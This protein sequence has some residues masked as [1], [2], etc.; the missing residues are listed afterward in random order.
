MIPTPQ[1]IEFIRLHRDDDVIQLAI[2]QRGDQDIDVPFALSQIR[3]Y[4]VARNKIPSW[5]AIEDIIYPSSLPLEQCS[6]EAT[7]EYKTSLLRGACSSLLDLTGGLGVDFSFMSKAVSDGKGKGCVYVERQAELCQCAAHNFPFLGLP[8]AE[9]VCG[10][11]EEYVASAGSF[12]VVFIDPA[13][14]N[15]G[16]RRTYA[17]AD[18]T[19]DVAILMPILFSHTPRVILK[20]SPML[21]WRKAINDIE[22]SCSD[23]H[24]S[25][26]HIVAVRNECKELLLV[27]CNEF[28]P[29]QIYCVNDRSVLTLGVKSASNS[30]HHRLSISEISKGSYLYEP[31]V[32]IMKCGCFDEVSSRYGVR[33]IAH[34]S[35]LFVSMDKIDHFPGRKFC[36]DKVTSMNRRDLRLSLQGIDQANITVRNFPLSAVQLRQRLKLGDGGPVYI[37]ATTL[38]DQSHILLICHSL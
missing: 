23:A 3:G 6:S 27:V 11:A 8:H 38:A 31:N 29:L 5:A 30:Q 2:S 4:Q 10:S 24:V 12:D 33:Q 14:R 1:T 32:S 22:K 35:H 34:S 9:I 25:E 18:C 26:V 28:A 36:I 20:L 15:S 16:G 37:F 17:I 7:A 13:R 21:D 19:P